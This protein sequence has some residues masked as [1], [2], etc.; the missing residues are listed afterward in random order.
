MPTLLHLRAL[1]RLA[2]VARESA[3]SLSGGGAQ[4]RRD[5]LADE[6]GQTRAS[7]RS[8]TLRFVRSVTSRG[9]RPMLEGR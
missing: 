4:C 7:H 6:T 5:R 9:L 8:I 1:F 3:K 2:D